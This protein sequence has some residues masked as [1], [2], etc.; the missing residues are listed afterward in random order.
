MLRIATRGSA[1]AR[2]Q[3]E[4]IGSLLGDDVEYVL[5]STTGDRDQQ[6]E[7]HAIGGQGVFTKE[8]QQAVLDGNADLAVHSAK[9]LPAVTPDG[10]VLGAVPER[11]DPRDALVGNTLAELPTGARDRYGVRTAPRAARGVASRPCVR[12][13]ARQHRDAAPQ[14]RGAGLRRGGGCVCRA[15]TARAR[16]GR[17]RCARS[18]RALA[19]GRS[20]GACR[21]VP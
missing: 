1:L 16:G 14:A 5:V 20:R 10:L 12:T 19:A 18:D 11:A 13:A 21:R 17:N 15:R 6:S 3:A 2:W 7:L 9:D 4:R 8:V